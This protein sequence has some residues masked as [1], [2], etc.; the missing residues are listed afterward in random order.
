M[1]NNRSKISLTSKAKLKQRVRTVVSTGAI[2]ALMMATV[3]LTTSIMDEPMDQVYFSTNTPAELVVCGDAQTFEVEYLNAMGYGLTGQELTITLPDGVEY[4]PGSIQNT[5]GHG[6]AESDISNIGTPVFTVDNV[7]D[8]ETAEFSIDYRA[9]VDG[10]TFMLEGNTPRNQVSLTATEGIASYEAEAYNI[11]YAS[12]NITS[13][14]PT[15][16]TIS[17]GDS[18]TRT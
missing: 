5:S 10:M 9:N 3:L 18:T 14:N 4:V 8:G 16:Q 2:T 13:L 1:S 6:V 12:L 17:S 15:S 11:I 7:D